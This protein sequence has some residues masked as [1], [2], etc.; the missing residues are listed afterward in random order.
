LAETETAITTESIV[1]EVLERF[2]ASIGVFVR[3]RMHC[4]GCPIAR[5]E[6]VAEACGIYRRPVE[7]FVAELRAATASQRLR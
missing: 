4:V 5:F 6:T 7:P 2:P 1:E 3:W